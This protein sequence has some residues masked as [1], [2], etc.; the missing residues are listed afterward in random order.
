MT[1]NSRVPDVI[2]ALVTLFTA[3]PNLGDAKVLDG[4]PVTD[5]PLFEAIYVGYDGDPDG[6]AET[7]T[8]EQ[9]WAG[10]GARAKNE[11]VT[12]TCAV[13][14]WKGDNNAAARKARRVRAFALLGVVEAIVRA[15]PSLGF[16]PPTVAAMASGQLFQR[17]TASGF[18]ARIPFQIQV[19]TRI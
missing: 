2:D 18:E 10:L 3:S 7:A 15:D 11:T 16:P 6:G 4:P 12:V 17:Q 19:Q 14:A 1:T 9:E 13:I 8:F 5:S